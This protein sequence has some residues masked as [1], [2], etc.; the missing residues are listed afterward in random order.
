MKVRTFRLTHRVIPENS[1]MWSKRAASF[2]GTSRLS[3][4][5]TPDSRTNSENLVVCK[6]K[7]AI[8]SL[9][10][11]EQSYKRNVS[12]TVLHVPF[13]HVRSEFHKQRYYSGFQHQHWFKKAAVEYW[14]L[15]KQSVDYPVSLR[16]LQLLVG[17]PEGSWET[18][19]VYVTL[20]L[21]TPPTSACDVLVEA[22]IT[23]PDSCSE[24]NTTMNQP[25][26]ECLCEADT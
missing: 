26:L 18:G 17:K 14:L 6:V 13:S 16:T 7:P 2:S 20:K 1:R 25:S 11:A 19:S 24:E 10:K 9:S 22:Y 4:P 21:P 12:Q 23:T 15:L 5:R 3:P 8:H